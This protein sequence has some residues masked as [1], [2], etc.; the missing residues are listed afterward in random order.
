MF[1]RS[2]QKP[3]QV[4]CCYCHPLWR[5]YNGKVVFSWLFWLM[6]KINYMTGKSVTKPLGVLIK[7]KVIIMMMLLP[8]TLLDEN[9]KNASNFMCNQKFALIGKEKTIYGWAPT[10]L[11]NFQCHLFWVMVSF[12]ALIA[13]LPL[14]RI[15]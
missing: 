13:N 11:T 3:C 12:F 5:V 4:K 8:M 10:S 1:W 14:C 7:I 9:R 6:I 15:H 2:I